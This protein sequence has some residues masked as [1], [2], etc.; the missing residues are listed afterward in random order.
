MPVELRNGFKERIDQI[1]NRIAIELN[2]ANV[3]HVSVARQ[4][5]PV[6][7]GES[8]RTIAVLEIATAE[9]LRAVSHAPAQNEQGEFYDIYPEFGT[10]YQDAQPFWTPAFQLARH[11]LLNALRDL[12]SRS[13]VSISYGTTTLSNPETF[14]SR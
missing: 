6:D 4:L 14:V 9:N 1:K 13:S 10:I 5:V 8:K 3:S 12:D 11:Q 7:T 2:A